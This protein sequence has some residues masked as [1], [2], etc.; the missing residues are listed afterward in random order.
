MPSLVG[1][2]GLHFSISF[3][4]FLMT[5]F[6]L[7]RRHRMLGHESLWVPGTDHAGI[8]TQSVVEKMLAKQGIQ[9]RQL[10]REEFVKKVWEWKEQYGSRI[11][12]QLRRLGSSL[13]WTRETFT[14]DKVSAFRVLLFAWKTYRVVSIETFG[15]CPGGLHPPA[16]AG[17]D[18]PRVAP[19]QLG[20]LFVCLFLLRSRLLGGFLMYR[21]SFRS[22]SCKLLFPTLRSTTSNSLGPRC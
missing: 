11:C 3:V 7:F 18:L 14:M 21:I 12:G 9:R 2:R 19:C 15:R 16:R 22:A 13:D 5:L 6:L 17:S 1:T 8:A 10:G 4:I 20:T